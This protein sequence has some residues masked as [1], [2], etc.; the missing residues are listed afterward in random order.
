MLAE[1]S[2]AACQEFFHRLGINVAH[3]VGEISLFMGVVAHNLDYCKCKGAAIAIIDGY[4]AFNSY[5]KKKISSTFLP[6]CFANFI[7]N[8]KVGLYL[9]FS[10]AMIVCL[11]TPNL[12]AKSSCRNPA[13]F[14]NV[15]MSFRIII[16]LN[17]C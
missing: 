1:K 5:S 17:S 15:F 9:S 11:L 14:L 13:L 8:S 7:A 10:I 2:F 4:R 3:E 16:T 12:S 6:N